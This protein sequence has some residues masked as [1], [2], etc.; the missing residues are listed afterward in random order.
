MVSTQCVVAIIVTTLY[1]NYLF[2]ISLQEG[3][4][5]VLYFF[6]FLVLSN[7]FT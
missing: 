4:H 3:G 7:V 6:I 1:Y 5:C 2:T